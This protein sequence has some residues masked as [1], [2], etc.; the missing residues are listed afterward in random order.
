MDNMT[1]ICPKCGRV[2]V[3]SI[4]VCPQC[5]HISKLGVVADIL[6]G[7]SKLINKK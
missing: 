5:G 4:S 6:K 7:V 1:K 2:Y 3:S